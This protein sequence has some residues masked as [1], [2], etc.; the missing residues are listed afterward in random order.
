VGWTLYGLVV[1]QYGDITDLM[2][3]SNQS[4]KDYVHSYFGFKNDFLLVVA[5][6]VLAFTVLFA[7][8]FGFSIQKFN[9]QKR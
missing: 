7:F 5:V 3:D 1:S 6:V 4:V 8:L 9:F 2:E